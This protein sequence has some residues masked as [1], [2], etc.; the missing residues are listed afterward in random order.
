MSHVKIYIET[1]EKFS[2]PHRT[3][4][5]V[6]TTKPEAI[7]PQPDRIEVPKRRSEKQDGDA[8]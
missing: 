7:E 1:E 4:E 2:A 6:K 3:T 5:P 8:A